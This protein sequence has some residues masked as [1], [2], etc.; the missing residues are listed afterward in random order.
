MGADCS[1]RL[2]DG[3]VSPA[4]LKKV[5]GHLGK[6]ALKGAESLVTIGL[7]T[8]SKGGWQ[9]HDWL[10]Y[11]PSKERV[12]AKRDLK[13]NR[14]KRWRENREDALREVSQMLAQVASTDARVDAS[15]DALVEQPVE[16]PPIP[17]RPDPTRS[18]FVFP[19][20]G[21]GASRGERD[22]EAEPAE[23][24]PELEPGEPDTPDAERMPLPRLVALR[25]ATRFAEARGGNPPG[26]GP[27]QAEGYAAIAAWLEKKNGDPERLLRTLL[28]G[29]FADAW[30]GEHGYPITALANDPPKYFAPPKVLRGSR[31]S[32]FMPP[33]QPED[34]EPAT[35]LDTIFGPKPAKAEGAE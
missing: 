22:P 5:L 31:R 11:Q 13:T 2:T 34:F 20:P 28:D 19:P 3:F 18:P 29:W 6:H 15:T 32:G 23:P 10:K 1:R 16:P 25:Y 4:R 27:K 35:D 12:E 26:H 8:V 9:Y 21:R 17:T 7:W 24:D 30:A 14:Q 33:S